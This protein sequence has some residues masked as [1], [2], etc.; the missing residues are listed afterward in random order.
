MNKIV[1]I[2]G[3][4]AGLVCS[5][6]LLRKG[7]HCILIEKKKYPFHRVCGEYISN[8]VKPFLQREK[9]FPFEVQTANIDEFELSA[10]NGKRAILPLGQGGFGIS[11]YY[12]DN[13]LFDIAITEGL[14]CF[15]EEA[16]DIR[17]TNNGFD[18]ATDRQTIHTDILICAHGKRSK[19]DKQL[20]REFIN[21]RSPYLG[22]KYHIK[23]THPVNRVSLHNFD[24]GYCGVNA[25]ENGVVNLCY[26]SHRNNLKKFKNISEME[27]AILFKNP[28]LREIFSNAEFLFDKPEVINE[29][30]FETKGPIEKHCLMVGDAAGMITPLSGNGMAMAMH[31]AY[32]LSEC[33]GKHARKTDFKRQHLESDYAQAWNQ[34]FARRL[35]RGRQIQ[36]LFGKK[37]LSNLSVNLALYSKPIAQVLI[38]QTH[39]K[40]F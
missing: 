24:E 27:E 16:I 21:K 1:I 7:F 30:S 32:V 39:G 28:H 22:V 15:Q 38:R 11:R 3:G 2:G 25:V 8:E 29:I 37:L 40:E 17:Y 6:R 23:Y 10:N 26:L 5:I 34:L 12:F 18:V 4:L 31:S 13:F 36:N 33:I 20:N 14:E 35:A 9:L 19:I